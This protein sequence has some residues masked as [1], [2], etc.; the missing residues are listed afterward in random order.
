MLN[1]IIK[2]DLTTIVL[3]GGK[4]KRLFPLTKNLPKPLVKINGKE[5]LTYILKNQIKYKLEDIILATGYKN[6]YFKNYQKKNSKKFKLK[7]VN[8]GLNTDIIKRLIKCEKY[9]KKYIMVCYGDTITDINIDKLLNFFSLNK[10]K[11]VLCSYNLKSQFG[12]MKISKSGKVKS[13]E[14]KPSLN[15]YFNIGYFIFKKDNLKYIK[16][17][18]SFQKFLESKKSLK[19]FRSFIHKG[20]HITVNTLHELNDAKKRLKKLN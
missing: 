3:C 13:F 20:D 18:N 10:S 2:N 11:I 16:S 12:L 7:L 4:G 14:E 8:S 6:N 19:K 9:C 1:K 17:F 15:F 5:I